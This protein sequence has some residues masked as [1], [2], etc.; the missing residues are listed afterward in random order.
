MFGIGIFVSYLITYYKV[1]LYWSLAIMKPG[2][3]A[4]DLNEML[5][6]D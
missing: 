3:N 1:D 2:T 6:F 4:L 5:S